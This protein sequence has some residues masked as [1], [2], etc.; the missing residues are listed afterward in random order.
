MSF[1]NSAVRIVRRHIL[2]PEGVVR[3]HFLR[4][5]GTAVV[6]RTWRS[7]FM[8]QLQTLTSTVTSVAHA[9]KSSSSSP[10][11]Q[12]HAPRAQL[13][14]DWFN[15]T[16]AETWGTTV[17]PM[18]TGV[19]GWHGGWSQQNVPVKYYSYMYEYSD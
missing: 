7:V 6:R 17:E 3:S 14:E 9:S 11:S 15:Y 5:L 4:L 19:G 12:V 10:H 18:L 2:S 8:H 1:R 16:I 13:T